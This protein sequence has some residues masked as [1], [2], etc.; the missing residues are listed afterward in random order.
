MYKIIKSNW[1]RGSG[2]TIAE[3]TCTSAED[4]ASLPTF[5]T[6]EIGAGSTCVCTADG[7]L[8]MLGADDVWHQL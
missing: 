2:C 1:E 4:I 7:S 5:A 8:W 6:D 3:F